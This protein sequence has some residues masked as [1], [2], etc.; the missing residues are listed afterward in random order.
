MKPDDVVAEF[1]EWHLA[2]AL[3]HSGGPRLWN[4]EVVQMVPAVTSHI[5]LAHL[6]ESDTPPAFSS[7]GPFRA[8]DADRYG[9]ENEHYRKTFW[10]LRPDFMFRAEGVM[11]L[12][13]AKAPG[14]S[15]GTWKDPKEKTYYQFLKDCS[16]AKTAFLYIVPGSAAPACEA[17]LSWHF[18]SS[19]KVRAGY[20][21]WEDLLPCLAPFLLEVAVDELVRA[22]RGLQRLRSW[23]QEQSP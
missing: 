23:Q 13:E 10:G 20:I 18:Q 6:F 7:E 3:A 4:L 15:P 17:S 8:E 5:S 19:S 1:R 14:V 22:S 16:I 9:F 21:L 11:I 2:L 12:L